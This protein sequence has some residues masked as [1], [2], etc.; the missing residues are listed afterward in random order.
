[1]RTTLL[2]L[3]SF[4]LIILFSSLTIALMIQPERKE[5][6]SKKGDIISK[7]ISLLPTYFG[8]SPNPEKDDR[9]REFIS[10]FSDIEVTQG[11]ERIERL[12]GKEEPIISTRKD[13]FGNVIINLESSVTKID[14][15]GKA[16]DEFK[17]ISPKTET[18]THIEIDKNIIEDK[19]FKGV[20]Y[21]DGY[22]TINYE[23]NSNFK[24]LTIPFGYNTKIKRTKTGLSGTIEDI[25]PV[26]FQVTTGGKGIKT[27]KG[28]KV[29]SR[30][31]GI[32]TTS[33][34]GAVSFLYE[35]SDRV[36]YDQITNK[37]ADDKRGFLHK[38]VIKGDDGN[39][40]IRYKDVKPMKS[41]HF[42]K[43]KEGTSVII[44]TGV[45]IPNK[46]L[47]N[48]KGNFIAITK[49]SNKN[50]EVVISPL[51]TKEGASITK[52]ISL[53]TLK[54]QDQ[55]NSIKEFLKKVFLGLSKKSK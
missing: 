25:Y 6:L 23:E 22:F 40:D 55:K 1:M 9:G 4:V 24:E 27:K 16:Y 17:R 20:T 32:D 34:I 51:I 33:A 54:K 52:D 21:K 10:L 31:E 13:L 19:D 15:G 46:V 29:I 36:I 37:L 30:S 39:E 45:A 42:A 35:K 18:L 43:S 2:T 12:E 5:V 49:E 50:G 8:Y 7:E 48:L 28:E 38:T 41:I 14:E 44:N 53:T 3:T 47:E 11:Q 26:A